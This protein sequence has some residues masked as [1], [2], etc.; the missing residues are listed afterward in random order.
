LGLALRTI[1]QW[2]GC[3]CTV[4][5]GSKNKA[6]GSAGMTEL[7][8]PGRVA[9]AFGALPFCRI[10]TIGR[11]ILARVRMIGTKAPQVKL[12]RRGLQP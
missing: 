12:P 9:Q 7:A 8:A 4:K 1:F 2:Y 6:Q 10:Q 11:G 3:R 5:T